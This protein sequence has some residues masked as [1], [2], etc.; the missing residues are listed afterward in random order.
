MPGFL[1]RRKSILAATPIVRIIPAARTPRRAR[2]PIDRAQ[3]ALDPR[4]AGGRPEA[5]DGVSDAHRRS[6]PLDVTSTLGR[7]SV[8]DR[9]DAG[10]GGAEFTAVETGRPEGK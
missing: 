1:I 5:H 2:L 6:I 8:V 10:D 4:A 7:E 9:G 3:G